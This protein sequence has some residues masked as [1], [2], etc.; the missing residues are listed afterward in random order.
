M[1]YSG[2][3]TASTELDQTYVELPTADQAVEPQVAENNTE[4][5]LKKMYPE[6]YGA[7]TQAQEEN[8]NTDTT[9]NLSATPNTDN[10]EYFEPVPKD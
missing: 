3:A 9:T 2:G 1:A 7:S 6:L 4:E 8:S 5:E 10:G